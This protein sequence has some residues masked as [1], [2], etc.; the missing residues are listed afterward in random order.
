[1]YR[2]RDA[3][4][5]AHRIIATHLEACLRDTAEACERNGLRQFIRGGLEFTAVETASS[6]VRASLRRCLAEA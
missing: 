4:H 2:P 1:M 3:E 5:A 6:E